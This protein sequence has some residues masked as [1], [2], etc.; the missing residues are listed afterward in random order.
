MLLLRWGCAGSRGAFL[1]KTFLCKPMG[2]CIVRLANPWSPMSDAEKPM[3]VS[4]W[5]MQPAF[6]VVALVPYVSSVNGMAV[7][8]PNPVK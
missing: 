1:D 6:A 5:S 4:V 2:H 7:R 8:P 3:E